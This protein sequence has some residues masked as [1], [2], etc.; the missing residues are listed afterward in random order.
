M[1]IYNKI[2]FKIV[3]GVLLILGVA[4]ILLGTYTI[5]N[6]RQQMLKNLNNQGIQLSSILAETSVLPIQKFSFFF[7]FESAIKVEQFPEVAFCEIYDTE[8]E[9]LVQTEG[10]LQGRQI[11]KKRKITGDNILIIEHPIK[12]GDHVLGNV[13]IGLFLDDVHKKIR[14]KTMQLCIFFIVIISIV[15]VLL[16]FFLSYFFVSPVIRLSMDTETIAQGQFIFTEI[17]KR[18]DEI[19][20]LAK[21]FNM[22]SKNL[23]HSFE[24]IAN[25]NEELE[26]RVEK[27]TGELQDA[28]HALQTS[29]NALEVKTKL[30]EVAKDEACAAAQAK[31]D[32][33]ANMSH[34]I[35]TPMN[36]VIA[37]AELALNETTSLKGKKFLSIIHS[38]GYSLL[39]IINDILDFSKIE[40]G[41][42]ELES[43]PFKID[44]LLE[45]IT[46]MFINKSSEKGIE[47][48]VDIDFGTPMAAIGDSLRLQQIIINLVGNAIKFIEKSGTIIIGVGNA[49]TPDTS[50]PHTYRFFVKDTGI[51]MDPKRQ[52]HLFE[53]FT[54]ADTSTTRKYGGT[55]LGLTICKQLVEM[56]NGG[57][58]VKSDLGKGSTFYFD[59]RLKRQH[60]DN[61]THF[62]LPSDLKDMK[63]LLVDDNSTNR[64]LMKKL[65]NS[66]GFQA[67]TASSGKEALDL[68]WKEE[69]K[70][71]FGLMI[72]DWLMP[73]MDGIQLT[74]IVREQSGTSIKIIM[75]TAF[76]KDE[77]RIEA[78]KAGI[79]GFITKPINPAL[80][81]GC[82]L[83][84]FNKTNLALSH[85]TTPDDQIINHKKQLQKAHILLAED[86][87]TNQE[88][89]KA[90]MD[91]AGIHLT[92]ADNGK[93]AV[94]A[95]TGSIINQYDAVLMDVQMPE[96]DG[97]EAAGTI[98]K[99][100]KTTQIEDAGND[101]TIS[102]IPI[103]AMTA[104]AMKGDKEKCIAAGMDDYITKPINQA[105]LFEILTRYVKPRSHDNDTTTENTAD[106]L[107]TNEEPLDSNLL[108]D[109]MPGLSI[110]QAR[111]SLQLNETV[112]TNIL[113]G[114][115][116][117]NTDTI[118]K[119][120]EAFTENN[121]D[122]LATIAHS[123]KGSSANI[124]AKNLQTAG[125][126][127]EKAI[128]TSMPLEDKE[129]RLN[130]NHL[131]DLV[132]SAFNP[133]LSSI[134]SIKPTPAPDEPMEDNTATLDPQQ[135]EP[136]L[137]HL[138][139]AVLHADPQDI[140]NGLIAVKHHL[141]H[142]LLKKLE[143]QL[144]NYEY[145][146][147]LETITTLSA[148]VGIQIARTR[149]T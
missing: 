108:P 96:M 122:A 85:K 117:S 32:F 121:W 66:Y 21:N 125:A 18:N 110:K 23:K 54:Q 34:E 1:K 71:P 127:L 105:Q 49:P 30:L 68:M 73:E 46:N 33:L 65:L 41:K 100:E 106:D 78:E 62:S 86:N 12:D 58:W 40:A 92:I 64:M 27:R 22:M 145:D 137:K 116:D 44:T 63:V 139:D 113:V 35:R 14:I 97:Y 148:E 111:E 6:Q 10:T 3:F 99:W 143:V 115:H 15:A 87:T 144:D 131:M 47:M 9:S 55:G 103:I 17:E 107:I 36:G 129:S 28:V 76:G 149:T 101:A 90:I 60:R 53:P 25:Q 91:A 67:E 132:V 136:I 104:H 48:L 133:V 72:T 118:Q 147:A 61:E 43:A 50:I 88:I 70:N 75:L 124:G 123:V 20:Q 98:R 142:R 120:N 83:Q 138:A 94:A 29:N 130:I 81:F 84:V 11:V 114:F 24:K 93:K 140:T 95:I 4:L 135:L 89:A 134:N 82:I 19:G 52:A 74:K 141:R 26:Q 8:N 79:N 56:M 31:S 112:F 57:I 119:M 146:D 69:G 37:A 42:L 38:S 59:I 51:G 126:D 13:E 109:E 39:G 5:G 102:P 2:R 7:L 128:K 77:E 80:M 16:S 45:K